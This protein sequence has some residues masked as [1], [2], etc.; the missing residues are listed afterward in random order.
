[1]DDMSKKMLTVDQGLLD[2]ST[3]GLFVANSVK[4]EEAKQAIVQ[5]AHSAM[6][7]QQLDLLD[8]FKI[9]KTADSPFP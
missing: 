4:A 2:G 7:N 1:M 9:I 3:Y 8:V 6:Q 5:L